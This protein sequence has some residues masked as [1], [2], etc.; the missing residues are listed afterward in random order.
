VYIGAHYLTDVIGGWVVGGLIGAG[1]AWWLRRWSY[2]RP[3]PVQARGV[4]VPQ[5]PT[6]SI[7]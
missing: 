7:S 5:A 3:V 4:P 6:E 1:V 2:F